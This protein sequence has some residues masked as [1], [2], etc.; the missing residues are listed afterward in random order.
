[1]K[2]SGSRHVHQR[3]PMRRPESFCARSTRCRTFGWS[4]DGGRDRAGASDEPSFG[5]RQ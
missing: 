5:R 1:L 4:P 2:Q 3:L